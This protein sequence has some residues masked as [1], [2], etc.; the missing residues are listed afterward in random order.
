MRTTD[1]NYRQVTITVMFILGVSNFNFCYRCEIRSGPVYVLRHFSFINNTFES[2]VYHYEDSDCHVPS[3]A[4]HSRGTYK[5]L[6]P[7]WTVLGATDAEYE[8]TRSYVITYSSG[9]SLQLSDKL[10]GRCFNVSENQNLRPYFRYLVYSYSPRRNP[11]VEADT[12]R[13][14]DCFREF[15][16]TLN[17]LQLVMV[18]TRSGHGRR[19][20]RPS[21]RNSEQAETTAAQTTQPKQRLQKP[22]GRGER[23][24]GNHQP[25]TGSDLTRQLF[26]GAVHSIPEERQS[27]RPSSFQSAL[28]DPRVSFRVRSTISVQTAMSCYQ[29]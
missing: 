29:S 5:L 3:Y 7:S 15:Q 1:L 10:S 13:D 27:Y 6:K 17:E 4:V 26:L 21:R 23:L 11:R 22:P 19:Q 2:V 25:R 9:S 14:V 18:E 24:R 16:F 20:R 12:Y 8:V 28:T